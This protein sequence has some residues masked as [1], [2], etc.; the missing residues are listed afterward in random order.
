MKKCV[1]ITFILCILGCIGMLLLNNDHKDTYFFQKPIILLDNNTLPIVKFTLK[2]GKTLKM[3]LDTGSEISIVDDD[4]YKE[5]TTAFNIREI[6]NITINTVNGNEQKQVLHS[7]VT[8]E[9]DM[10]LNINI[11]NIDDVIDNVFINNVIFIDGII[12]CDFLYENG[13]VIDFENKKITNI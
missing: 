9:N 2:N 7:F 12:G 3:L 11:M 13:I 4:I 1:I 8:L 6:D 10:N 5:D